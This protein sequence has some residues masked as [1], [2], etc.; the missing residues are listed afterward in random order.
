MTMLLVWWCPFCHVRLMN[1]AITERI[2][3]R[4]YRLTLEYQYRMYMSTGHARRG[5]QLTYNASVTPKGIQPSLNSID[6]LN[7]IV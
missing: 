2:Q 3:T 7:R 1:S 4:F 5:P 6:A